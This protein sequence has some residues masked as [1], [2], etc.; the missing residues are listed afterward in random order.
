MSETVKERLKQ[1]PEIS[2]VEGTSFEQFL[3]ELLE[4]Y[5][6]KYLELT[7]RDVALPEAD[8]IRLILY[9][10]SVLLYQGM[11]YIDR[12]G[13]MGLLKYSTGEFLDNLAA[14]KKV[15]RLSAQTAQAKVRFTLS[16]LREESVSIPAGTRV[17]G[18]E[19]FWAT[20]EYGEIP[21]GSQT[22]EL[23]VRCLT[24][25]SIGNGLLPGEINILVDPIN[26]IAKIENTAVSEGGEDQET[27]EALADRIYLAPSAYTTAGP[28]D[29]YRYWTM[30]YSSAIADCK[31]YSENPGE[32]DIYVMLQDGELPETDFLEAVEEYLAKS[33]KKPLTDLVK[34]KAPETEEYRID[35]TYYIRSSDRDMADTIQKQA[36]DACKSYVSWQQ[37]AIAR[38][39]NPSRLMYELMRAG[40]KWVDIRSPVFT[41]IT[42]AKIAKASEVNLVYGGLQDD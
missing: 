25:G 9:S 35:A 36:E 30:S 7:G 23:L 18:R 11:Q 42:G 33:D 8:P 10:C 2:F 37:G 21:A 24:A 4:T 1:Y 19:L 6:K 29:A 38:D 3:S 32:V 13:K 5:Q 31:I 40:V 17:K 22:V 20:Q 12:A 16:A 34:V 28:E 26:Y 15:E 41:E 14:L 39:I 27:D